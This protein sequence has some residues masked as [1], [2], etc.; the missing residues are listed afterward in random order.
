MKL[1]ARQCQSFCPFK[2]INL[3]LFS[4]SDDNRGTRT[5]IEAV[6]LKMPKE[7]IPV[8]NRL[9]TFSRESRRRFRRHKTDLRLTAT[10]LAQPKILRD[11]F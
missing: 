6:H 10:V 9:S 2:I 11:R 8:A 5:Y 7:R 1:A 3:Y 4:V